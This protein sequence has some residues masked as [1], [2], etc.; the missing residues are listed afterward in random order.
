MSMNK[1]YIACVH[2]HVGSVKLMCKIR[3]SN[4]QV[5]MTSTVSVTVLRKRSRKSI[6]EALSKLSRLILQVEYR[7]IQ[8]LLEPHLVKVTGT[9]SLAD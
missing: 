7:H 8:L 6:H 2:I 9:A 1:V 5:M 4:Y 3:S